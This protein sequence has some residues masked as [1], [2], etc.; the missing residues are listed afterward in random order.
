MRTVSIVQ[1]Y[2]PSYRVDFFQRLAHELSA[3]DVRIKVIAGDPDDA[4]LARGDKARVAGQVHASWRRV[5]VRSRS[6]VIDPSF[7]YWRGSDAVILPLMGSSV[8]VYEAILRRGTSRLGLWGHVGSYVE[9]GNRI[10]LSLERWQM[11]RADRVFAYTAGGAA[12]AEGRGVPSSKVTVVQN[13]ID[14]S[15]LRGST[16]DF[17][18]KGDPYLAY[19]GGLDG[20]KRVE[21]LADA[22]NVLHHRRVPIRVRVAGRGQDESL[23]REA[24]SRG[25]VDLIGYV[26][27]NTKAEL[28]KRCQAIVIPGRIGL[29]AV[30]ALAVGRPILTAQ[31]ALHAP[32]NEYLVEGESR[33]TSPA[34]PEAFAELLA[35]A[36][37]SSRERTSSW[38]VPSIEDM[39]A[40]FAT[41]VRQM[42]KQQP[43]RGNL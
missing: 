15:Y 16:E 31:G 41:G 30:E 20:S 2:V 14:T 22:L 38:L 9:R 10:D 7:Q 32:E 12:F 1:P 36:Y 40:N 24:Q 17:Q 42:L 8:G 4:Q 43:G 19:I 37:Q 29:V 26:A 13:A 11:A 6:F 27:G 35:Q 25:Q 34:S 3:D 33:F 39:V 5:R 23:L 18:E 28:L 21:L